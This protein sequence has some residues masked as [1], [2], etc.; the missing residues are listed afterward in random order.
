MKVVI[1]QYINGDTSQVQT[2]KDYVNATYGL[3]HTSNP[4]GDYTSGGLGEPKFNVDGTGESSYV[5]WTC[6]SS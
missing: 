1:N 3:Q 5:E 4:S 6:F 2:I